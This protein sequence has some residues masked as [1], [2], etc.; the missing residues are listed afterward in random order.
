V[1]SCDICGRQFKSAQGLNGHVRFKHGTAS[2]AQASAEKGAQPSAPVAESVSG[3]ANDEPLDQWSEWRAAGFTPEILQQMSDEIT[4]MSRLLDDFEPS[5]R[6]LTQSLDDIEAS[7]RQVTQSLE[8]SHRPGFCDDSECCGQAKA[9]FVSLAVKQTRNRVF[10]TL[11]Q[12]SREGDLID[13]SD[14]LGRRFAAIEAGNPPDPVMNI[15]G[16]LVSYP[17]E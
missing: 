12:A 2:V 5:V 6:Q 17:R 1:T 9:D 16:M 7:V 3:A 15:E 4:E 10:A 8:H 11:A 14:R 13:D